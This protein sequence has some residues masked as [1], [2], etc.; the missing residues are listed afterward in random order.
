MFCVFFHWLKVFIIP[1][2]GEVSK[3]NFHPKAL[4]WVRNQAKVS[5]IHEIRTKQPIQANSNCRNPPIQANSYCRNPL[6]LNRWIPTVAVGLNCWIPTVA[7]G[8]LVLIWS[9]LDSETLFFYQLRGF[10]VKIAHCDFA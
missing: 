1:K 10:L 7:V 5:K 3:D 4:K 8:L 6:I 2:L 9:I